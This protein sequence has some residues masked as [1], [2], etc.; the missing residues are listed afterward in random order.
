MENITLKDITNRIPKE[1]R[2][3]III[4]SPELHESHKDNVEALVKAID[5]INKKVLFKN[6]FQIKVVIHV[7]A[8]PDYYIQSILLYAMHKYISIRL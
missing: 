2:D 5:I 4:Q 7:I 3:L 6:K 8:F 1:I